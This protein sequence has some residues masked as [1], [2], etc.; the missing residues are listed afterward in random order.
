MPYIGPIQ[1]G[2]EGEASVRGFLRLHALGGTLALVFASAL[3]AAA[4][5][6]EVRLQ[7]DQAAVAYKQTAAADIQSVMAGVERMVAALQQGDVA[8]AR[9]AWID[10]R[11]GW[12]RS[13]IFT[14][15]LFPDQ[16]KA[17]DDWPALRS[18]FHAVEIGL[19]TPNQ[20]LPLAVALEL[21][22]RLQSFQ[23]VF[24]QASFTGFYLRGGM[25]TQIYDIGR[26]EWTGRE[27]GPSGTSL[28]DLKHNFEGLDRA[29]RSIFAAAV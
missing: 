21:L 12:E 8:M 27:S 17:I 16:D 23:R 2:I 3:P 6:E 19:F 9:A 24:A 4:S 28:A 26:D 1:A 20:P 22:D 10:A 7:L 29:W 14:V 5:D 11:V 13:E 18:G 15:D 25:A